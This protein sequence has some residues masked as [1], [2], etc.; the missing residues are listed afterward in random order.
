MGMEPA[1]N[2][3]NYQL[4]GE[5]AGSIPIRSVSYSSATRTVSLRFAALTPDRYELWVSDALQSRDGLPLREPFVSEFLAISDFSA[6]AN[7]QFSML[8]SNRGRGT[9]LWG[10]AVNQT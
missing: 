7:I 3:N 1:F 6:Y 8:G 10:G 9:V 4:L 2:P 5:N